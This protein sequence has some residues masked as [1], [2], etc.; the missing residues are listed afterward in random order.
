MRDHASRRL[1]F[2]QQKDGVRRAAYFK[3]SGQLLILAFEKQQRARE[4]IEWIGNQHRRLFDMWRNAALRLAYGLEAGSRRCRT[5]WNVHRRPLKRGA[6]WHSL[7]RLGSC[8]AKY[9]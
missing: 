9:V 2:A 8:F 1:R 6:L 4:F 5:R 7:S 3:R